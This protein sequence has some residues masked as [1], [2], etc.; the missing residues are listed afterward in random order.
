MSRRHVAAWALYD[1]ANSAYPAVVQT[2]VFSVYY[3]TIVVG[4]AHGRGDWWWGRAVS[5]SVLIVALTAPLLGAIA[6]RAGVRKRLLF[7]FT[8]MCLLGVTLFTTIKPGMVVWGFV[9]YVFANVGFEGAL[10]FYNAYLPDI[11]PPEKQ[12]FVSGLGFGV[13]YL[14]SVAGLLLGWVLLPNLSLVWLSV[15]VF[16]AVFS[17]P[18]FL[19]LPR[20]VRGGMTVSRAAAWGLTG[21]RQIVRDA[22]SIRELRRF[23]L[24][25]FFYIDGILTV[26]VVAGPF[27]VSSFGFDTRGTIVL[28]LVVQVSA[29]LGAFALARPTDRFGPKRILDGVILLW[30]VVGVTAYFIT[31]QRAFIVLAVVAGFGLGSAQ[32]ASRSFMASLIPEGKEAEMF[33][34]YAFCGKSSSILGPALFGYVSERSGGNQHLAVLA[35]TAMYLVGLV[36][37]QRV[38]DP[39]GAAASSGAA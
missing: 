22:L 8:S 13:G 14:G 27:A 9:L 2:A 39:R 4:N 24:A 17:T 26:I 29:L 12:G 28:F 21:F 30:V 1:F 38:R 37:L 35:I 10:V 33:G 3:T 11:A 36:L 31:T 6:D 18:T 15:V 34:F 23:L 25:Y 32:A 20:D 5:T 7:L 19:V 16:F